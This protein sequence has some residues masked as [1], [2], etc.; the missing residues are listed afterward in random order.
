[1]RETGF[2]KDSVRRGTLAAVR[3]YRVRMLD[4]AERTHLAAW[5]ARIDVERLVEALPE[6]R[7]R[8]ETKMIAEANTRDRFRSLAKLTVA[9]DGRRRFVDEPPVLARV[10]HPEHVAVLRDVLDRYPQSLTR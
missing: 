5:Y 9:Q 2:P 10:S 6:G 7:L 1:M 4:L 8:A 3:G